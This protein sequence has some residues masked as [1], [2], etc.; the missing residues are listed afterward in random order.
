MCQC[1]TM[2]KIGN[3]LISLISDVLSKNKLYNITILIIRPILRPNSS[4]IDVVYQFEARPCVLFTF[5]IRIYDNKTNIKLI[6][7]YKLTLK[8]HRIKKTNLANT[9][10]RQF[11]YIFCVRLN[12]HES[13]KAYRSIKFMQYQ[14]P[15]HAL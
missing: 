13:S 6:R 12:L 4:I 8:M 5:D 15:F 3:W 10:N 1:F 14:F 2:G 7:L 9:I 11:Q